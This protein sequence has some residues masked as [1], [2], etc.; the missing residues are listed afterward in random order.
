MGYEIIESDA[1]RAVKGELNRQVDLKAKGRFKYTPKDHEIDDWE[2]L[3][4]LAEE[5]GEV[6]RAVLANSELVQEE[7]SAEH[8][9]EELV[10]VA[11]V[12]VAWIECLEDQ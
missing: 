1:I 3:A 5:I 9:R 2:K 6:A 12:A 7:P 4:M 10:Q 11:A 8:L